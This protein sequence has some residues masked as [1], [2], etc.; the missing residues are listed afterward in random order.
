MRPFA[1]L[2]VAF[3]GAASALTHAVDSSS[4]VSVDIYK[5]ALGQGFTRAIFRGY[6]EAC[7][8]GGRVD[9][10]FVPSYKNAVAAGYKD[11]DA[12]FFPCTGKANKCKPYATQLRELLDTISAQKL[13]IRRIWLDIETDKVCNPFDYGAQGNIAEA[14]KLV[15][16]FRDAKHDWGVYTSPTQW[17]SIFG[18]KSVELAKDVPLWFAKF[19]NVET[20]DLKTP[21]G[22]WTKADAKQYTDQSASKKFDLN[23]FSA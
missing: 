5:K 22:G 11:F 1:V 10:T 9:P 20:L 21:F 16:A 13:A 7:S 2:F 19:D 14:K 8:Q 6:Q 17:E 15:A 18:S 23:V 3:A 12:Y 4:E